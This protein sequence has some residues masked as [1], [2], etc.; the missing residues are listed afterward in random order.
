MQPAPPL[1]IIHSGCVRKF[2]AL[3]C[4]SPS[5]W[6][7]LAAGYTVIVWKTPRTLGPIDPSC[8]FI[9]TP[10]FGSTMVRVAILGAT[11]YTALEL[12]KM[13]LRHP[14]VEITAL[15]SRQE[16]NPHVG[17]CIRH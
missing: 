8:S 11:G 5:P 7:A 9:H 16:G 13:L 15:T 17:R 2:I 4:E 3:G 12:I 1:F 10:G 6:R 14:E